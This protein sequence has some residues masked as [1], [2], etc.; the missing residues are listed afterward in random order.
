MDAAASHKILDVYTIGG[1]G[2][3]TLFSV[4]HS[5]LAGAGGCVSDAAFGSM[6]VD[7]VGTNGS[8]SGANVM[9]ADTSLRIP[10]INQAMQ[11]SPA[12]PNKIKNT[13]R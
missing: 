7:A 13:T 11:P 3:T 5:G 12:I 4:S 9:P 10:E 2:G 8:V 1:N 6:G